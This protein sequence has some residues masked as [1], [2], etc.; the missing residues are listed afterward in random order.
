MRLMP[1]RQARLERLALSASGHERMFNG[2]A[3]ASG[4]K[5]IDFSAGVAWFGDI[6]NNSGTARRDRAPFD[7]CQF[8]GRCQAVAS[9]GESAHDL[10]PLVPA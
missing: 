4:E 8:G 10:N 7:P 1:I 2:W 9:G 6:L 3:A 5:R